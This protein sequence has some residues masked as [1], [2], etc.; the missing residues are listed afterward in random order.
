MSPYYRHYLIDDLDGAFANVGL[1]AA[2]TWP[3]F[4]AKVM[5]WRKAL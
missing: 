4:L 1:A 3:A 2:S 5:V